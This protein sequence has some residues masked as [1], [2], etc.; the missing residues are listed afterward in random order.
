MVAGFSSEK[1]SEICE[2]F[3]VEYSIKQNAY[4]IATIGE[5]LRQNIGSNLKGKL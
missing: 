3:T 1:C 2:M 4:H 5:T